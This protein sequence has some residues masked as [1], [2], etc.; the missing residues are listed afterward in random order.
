[1]AAAQIRSGTYERPRPAARRWFV[2]AGFAA[3]A[4]AIVLGA[5]DVLFLGF[6]WVTVILGI[7]LTMRRRVG[8]GITMIVSA[9]V[10]TAPAV[11]LIH[12]IAFKPY[13]IHSTAMEPTV[14][15]GDLVVVDR[16]GIDALGV[17][18]IVILHPPEGAKQEICGAARPP[19]AAC[20]EPVP[21]ESRLKYVRR[22]VAGPGD[23]IYIKEGDVLRKAAGSKVFLREQVSFIGGTCTRPTA[24]A[25][26]NLPVP[27]KVPGGH[28]FVMGDN[29]GEPDDSRSWGPVPSS[30]IVGPAF[31][32]V[33]GIGGVSFL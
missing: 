2:P 4:L 13:R 7:M 22:I 19:G 12:A 31:I 20:S 24:P 14:E 9:V 28:W 29:R 5:V 32:R 21:R 30:W 26:C 6:G 18:E 17:G 10:L 23:E 33:R 16:T 15:T 27:L 1:M 8:V 3:L 11:G 25:M